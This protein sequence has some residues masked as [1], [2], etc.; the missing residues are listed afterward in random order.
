M[1]F[2]ILAAALALGGCSR[3]GSGPSA[4]Q[5]REMDEAAELL[6]DAPNRLANIDDSELLVDQENEDDAARGD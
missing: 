4:E 5:N 6:D 3:E 1:R 2:L